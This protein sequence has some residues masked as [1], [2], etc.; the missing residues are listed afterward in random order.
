MAWVYRQ[1]MDSLESDTEYVGRLAGRYLGAYNEIR[2][3]LAEQKLTKLEAIAVL[4]NL[5]YSYLLESFEKT[6]WPKGI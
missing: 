1:M 6:E 5:K 3:I 4:E 2:R